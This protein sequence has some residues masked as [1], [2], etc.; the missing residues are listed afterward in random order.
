MN[1]DQYSCNVVIAGLM[2]QLSSPERTPPIDA[3]GT[4]ALIFQYGTGTVEFHGI[5][6]SVDLQTKELGMIDIFFV[7]GEGFLQAYLI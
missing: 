1:P 2:T 7:K 5:N 4:R 3:V 6:S